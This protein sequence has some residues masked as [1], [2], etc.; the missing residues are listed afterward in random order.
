MLL[1]DRRRP[2]GGTEGGRY[3]G[4]GGVEIALVGERSGA[5]AYGFGFEVLRPPPGPPKLIATFPVRV[6]SCSTMRAGGGEKTGVC[7]S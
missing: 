5:R 3:A 4:G 6:S 2:R 7:V 1:R